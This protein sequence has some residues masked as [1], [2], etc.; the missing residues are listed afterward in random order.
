VVLQKERHVTRK[1]YQAWWMRQERRRT[2]IHSGRILSWRC[3]TYRAVHT[4]CSTRRSRARTCL[5]S[6][7]RC[8]AKLHYCVTRASMMR[9]QCEMT[10][11]CVRTSCVS[12]LKR[13][14]YMSPENSSAA[15]VCCV[16]CTFC[17][18]H[19]RR[20]SYAFYANN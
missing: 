14:F 13:G 17:I 10:T 3:S 11:Q 1:R 7:S 2:R 6:T 16:H 18:P 5:S 4:V 19:F 9:R 15:Q 8:R 12:T 20:T